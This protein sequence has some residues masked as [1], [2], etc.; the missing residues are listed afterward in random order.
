MLKEFI[1]ETMGLDEFDD[2]EF[3]TQID[4]IDVLSATELIFCFK[5][6]RK[7]HRTWNGKKVEE[8]ND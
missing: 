1:A 4:Q 5:D 2:D 6:G 7:L 3:R 8:A